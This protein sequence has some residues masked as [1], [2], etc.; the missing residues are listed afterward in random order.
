MAPDSRLYAKLAVIL[1]FA[2]QSLQ[3]VL[4]AQ[5]IAQYALQRLQVHHW[6]AQE[7]GGGKQA[8]GR[9]GRL[10]CPS[11]SHLDFD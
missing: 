7:F 1:G 4:P 11:Q 10:T 6:Y 9:T 5:C 2:E 8:R 3:Q